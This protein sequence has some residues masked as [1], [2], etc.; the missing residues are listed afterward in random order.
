MLYLKLHLIKVKEHIC[1]TNKLVVVQ[2]KQVVAMVS[3]V[4][5][6]G[7]S[8]ICLITRLRLVWDLG[9]SWEAAVYCLMK[10]DLLVLFSLESVTDLTRW[11]AGKDFFSLTF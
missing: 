9:L 10:F 11:T 4:G 2:A 3:S 1:C 6:W 5:R 7:S 8:L